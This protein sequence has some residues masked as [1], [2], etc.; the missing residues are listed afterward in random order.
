ME[1]S[2][3]LKLSAG[4]G[5]VSGQINF[6]VLRFEG[7]GVSI[8]YV[9][10]A[11]Y[12]NAAANS[13]DSYGELYDGIF[14]LEGK[15]MDVE[16]AQVAEYFGRSADQQNL[17]MRLNLGFCLHHGI[18]VASNRLRLVEYFK[19]AADRFR[20]VAQFSD[21]LYCHQ[22]RAIL[23]DFT[24]A[25][26][27]IKLSADQSFIPRFPVPASCPANHRVDYSGLSSVALFAGRAC[28]FNESGNGEED[29]NEY[30]RIDRAL[31][32]RAVDWGK[33]TNFRNLSI[34]R[35]MIHTD[36]LSWNTQ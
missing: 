32:L 15:G 24:E 22:G 31:L 21:G 28:D 2:K 19:E 9:D 20:A 34:S 18:D 3:Y 35:T 33:L 4:Q 36:K 30:Q 17:S 14:L 26:E 7:L 23:N 12:F 25:S 29:W 6:G 10:A 11:K 13:G 1:T 16:V 8:D 27:Y 5:F